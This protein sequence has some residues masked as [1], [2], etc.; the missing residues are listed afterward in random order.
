M[1]NRL[2]QDRSKKQVII[3]SDVEA[4]Y[5]SLCDIKVAEIVFDAIMKTE[6]GFEGVNYQEGCRYIVLNCSEQECRSGPLRR[7][8]PRRRFVKG[9]R[10]GVTGDLPMG[11]G[12]GDQE[13]WK[14]P[15]VK[16]TKLEKR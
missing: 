11:A 16:L 7:V 3:G 15:A 4:L 2:V 8:L 9:S 10:P 1:D 14:F 12:A 6:V 5:P 13:Q